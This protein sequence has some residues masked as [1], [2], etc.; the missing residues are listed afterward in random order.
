MKLVKPPSVHHSF[1]MKEFSGCRSVVRFFLGHEFSVKPTAITPTMI[2]NHSA[3]NHD[4]VKPP[5]TTPMMAAGMHFINCAVF[6][7]FQNFCT[8]KI[9]MMHKMGSIM[10]A[11]RV[12]DVWS[13]ISGTASMPNAP[14]KPPLEMPVMNTATAMSDISSQSI[15]VPLLCVCGKNAY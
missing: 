1:P 12:G 10:A 14:E 15:D 6:H 3:E 13:E 2:F 4:A 5:M 7:F 11:A 8:V 9:S